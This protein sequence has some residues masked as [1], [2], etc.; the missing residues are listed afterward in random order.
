MKVIVVVDTSPIIHNFIAVQQSRVPVMP[1]SHEK[2][3][4]QKHKQGNK[5]VVSSQIPSSSNNASNNDAASSTTSKVSPNQSNNP[6][7]E[8]TAASISQRLKS[9][10]AIIDKSKV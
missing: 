2:R 4:G 7:L 1:I 10:K 3:Y 6:P 8:P 9:L 5:P